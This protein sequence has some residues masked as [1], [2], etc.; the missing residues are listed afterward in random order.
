MNFAFK[1]ACIASVS[2]TLASCSVTKDHTQNIDA[3]PDYTGHYPGFTLVLDERFDEFND[4]IW[5]KGDGAVGGEAFCRFQPQGVQI[6]DGI[7]ELV[8]REEPVADSY[9]FDHQQHKGPYDFSCGELRTQ[10]SK[11]IRYGRIETRMKAP[12]RQQAS[13]YIS[14]LFT[15]T[16]DFDADAP[17]AGKQEWEEIDIE[18]EG[19]RP[20]KFQANLIYGRNTWEWWRTREFGAWEDKIDVGPVDEWRVFA[21]EWVPGAI[22]WYVDGKLV[23]TLSQED[24]DCQP[25]CVGPQKSP[26][27]IPDNPTAVI[28]NFWIPNDVIQNEFGGNKRDNVYPMKTQYDWLRYYQLDSHP[29]SNW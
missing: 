26:T 23:K 1:T 14:S 21:I 7:L 8:I 10:E 18:L 6:V 12:A 17:N 28:M 11:T 27:P 24:I 19:G 3:Y 16:N 5:R 13:G 9:S 25:E 22:R 2:I 20:D 29:A 15:Y 4:R